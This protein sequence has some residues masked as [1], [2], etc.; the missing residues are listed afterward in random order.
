M[1]VHIECGAHLLSRW[2][3]VAIKNNFFSVNDCA[4]CASGSSFVLFHAVTRLPIVGA[5]DISFHLHCRLVGRL[6][7]KEKE[8]INSRRY[9]VKRHTTVIV[10]SEHFP[11]VFACI[12]CSPF[13]VHFRF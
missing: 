9:T 10:N 7:E 2:I 8:E 12:E 6:W 4:P 13:I 3:G 11:K 5:S 1:L